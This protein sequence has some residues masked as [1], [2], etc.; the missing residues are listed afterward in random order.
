MKKYIIILITLVIIT[1]GGIFMKEQ[2]DKK[3]E[4]QE[5]QQKEEL[6]SLA[7]K[8]M[9]DFIET[10]YKDIQSIE[11]TNDYEINPMGGISINGYLNGNKDKK[12]WGIYDKANDEVGVFKV[13]AT[14]KPECEDK[15]CE[16]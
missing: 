12:I 9:N 7:K 8:R 5:T 3:I 6:Y 4:A 16:Y 14:R 2:H 10:N 11:Y 1:L 13:N 15:V